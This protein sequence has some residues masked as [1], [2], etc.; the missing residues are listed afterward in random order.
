MRVLVATDGSEDAKAAT[1]WFREFPLPP[2]SELRVLTA[3]PYPYA[4]PDI[5]P[6]LSDTDALLEA[7]RHAAEEGRAVL[8]HRWRDPAV[9]AVEGDPRDVIVRTADEWPA[10]LIVVG[11]RGLGAIKGFLLGSVSKTVVRHASCP[12]LVVKGRPHLLRKAVIAIDGSPD[13]LAAARFFASLPLDR[14]MDVHLLAVVR[15]P[16]LPV[17][18]PEIPTANLWTAFDDMI[19]ERKAELA[20]VLANV[21][22]DFRGRVKSIERSVVIGHPAEEIWRAAGEAN[23]DLVVV[24]ARGLGP[25]KRL[26]LGSVSEAVLHHVPCPVLVVK[27]PRRSAP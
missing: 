3:A 9:L 15:P 12:V 13:S 24:G 4:V 27:G 6:A 8:A 1:E 5:P 20:G 14:G 10:D 21:E 25:L 26:L 18:A 11:A 7:A 2:E 19:R 22:N 16:S 23:V 17:A